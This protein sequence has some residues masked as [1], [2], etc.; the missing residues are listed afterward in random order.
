MTLRQPHSHTIHTLNNAPRP[1]SVC[2]FGSLFFNFGSEKGD[3]TSMATMPALSRYQQPIF[4]RTTKRVIPMKRDLT[5]IVNKV[6]NL[7]QLTQT[8]GFQTGR[9]ICALLS[10]LTPDELAAV[11]EGLNPTPNPSSQR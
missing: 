7:K 3:I 10:D 2:S 9:S 5:E 4:N 11:N 8:T 6:R 1:N